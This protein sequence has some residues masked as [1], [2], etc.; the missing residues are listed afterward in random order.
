MRSCCASI[1]FW[2]MLIL[3]SFTAPLAA[4]T[5]FSMMGC[6]CLHGPHH[7][8]QKSTITGTVREASST[9]LAN[10][11]WSLSL[12]RSAGAASGAA[13]FSIGSLGPRTGGI[14]VDRNVAPDFRAR[15]VAEIPVKSAIVD[16][17][18][19]AMDLVGREHRHRAGAV[20]AGK[21]RGLG[22]LGI[23]HIGGGQR[24]LATVEPFDAEIARR[25]GA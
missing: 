3:T 15:K 19:D 20:G 6:S 2:S 8:A 18:G 4:F 9:S 17:G 12:M 10:L 13:P 21:G 7:G 11:V 24:T 22:Q 16:S 5:T 23:F 14:C 1:W 25:I